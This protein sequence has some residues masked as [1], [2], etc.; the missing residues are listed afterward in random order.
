MNVNYS[1]AKA[2][3]YYARS[4]IVMDYN[5]GEVNWIIADANKVSKKYKKYLLS[6][7]GDVTYPIS[8]SSV[9]LNDGNLA[10]ISDNKFLVTYKVDTTSRLFK[11]VSNINFGKASNNVNLDYT[12]DSY[13]VTAD[14]VIKKVEDGTVSDVIKTDNNI[15][16]LEWCTNSYNQLEANRMGFCK[17][18]IKKS[19]EAT[20]KPIS[21][22]DLDGNLITTY[23]SLRDATNKTNGSYKSISQCACGKVKSSGGFIWKYEVK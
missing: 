12:D 21:Q 16:N 23:I 3:E 13:Y 2:V 15:N 4:Y 9:T 20:R 18:R 17:N 14:N 7:D 5:T 8:P 10:Y 19:T 1:R 22:Y 11:E 6:A